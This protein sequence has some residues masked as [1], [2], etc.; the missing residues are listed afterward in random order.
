MSTYIAQMVFRQF[1][2]WCLEPH[3][4]EPPFRLGRSTH[5]RK[6]HE[7]TA[8]E[9]NGARTKLALDRTQ[10]ATGFLEFSA[11]AR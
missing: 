10:G 4:S 6:F 7:P 9:R 2:T 3:Y 1:S 11:V 8:R 5:R